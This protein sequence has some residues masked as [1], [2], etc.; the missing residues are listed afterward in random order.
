MQN[1]D[2]ELYKQYNV[3][4]ITDY[5][6]LFNDVTLKGID[7][8]LFLKPEL[9]FIKNKDEKIYWEIIKDALNSE[10][11]YITNKQILTAVK[12]IKGGDDNG[13]VD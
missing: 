13:K 9:S 12:N 5:K 3:I 7:I 11:N 4:L 6:D 2:I 8:N 10:E 1:L